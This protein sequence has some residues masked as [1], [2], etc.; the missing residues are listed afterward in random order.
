MSAAPAPA[1]P[2]ALQLAVPLPHTHPPVQIHLHLTISPCLL[3]LFLTTAAASPPPPHP[4]SEG[5][6]ASRA[7]TP[8]GS[9]VVAMPNP[10]NPALNPLTTPLYAAPATLDTAARIARAL[11]ARTRR[12]VYVGSAVDL[13][14]PGAAAS[15]QEVLEG[16]RRVVGCVAAEVQ[17][18]DGVTPAL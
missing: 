14:A 13:A 17:R 11:A 1:A 7:C 12:Q 3:L 16:I 5:G 10:S 2:T 9:F 18:V 8:L 15:A 4:P 6:A